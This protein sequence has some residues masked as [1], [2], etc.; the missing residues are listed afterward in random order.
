MMALL[1]MT[2]VLLNVFKT[3]IS[4]SKDGKDFG[5]NYKIQ[6]LGSVYL[7]NGENKKQLIDLT[8]HDIN[9]FEKF[10]GQEI[11]FPV[12]V[13]AMAKNQAVFFIPK[14]AKPELGGLVSAV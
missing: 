3:P 10:E 13:V 7:Q 14:G 5:G 1:T 4:Q 8:C 2:G 11:C 6:V 9:E 12:G